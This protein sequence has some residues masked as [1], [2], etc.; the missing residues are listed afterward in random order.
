MN[1]HQLLGNNNSL[2]I[3]NS[4]SQQAISV[5]KNASTPHNNHDQNQVPYQNQEEVN[6]H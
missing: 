3:R 4:S 2:V 1:N 5:G 6:G